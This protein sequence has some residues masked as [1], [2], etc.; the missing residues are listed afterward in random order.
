MVDKLSSNMDKSQRKVKDLKQNVANANK[1]LENTERISNRLSRSVGKLA[2]AFAIKE[3]VANVTKVRGQFQQLE[4]A[5]TTMLQSAEKADAL[6]QQL[7]KTAATTPFGLEDVAQGA[8]QL[9][10]YGFEAEKVNE[11]LIRLGD[12]AAG[13]SVPLNDLVYLYGTTMAQ[14]RL[15]TQDL[16]QFTGRGIPMIS[17]LAKQFGVAESKVKELVEEGKVGFPEVQKVIESLTNEGG[18]F[19]GLMEAQS[20]TITGQISNIEDSFQMM[21]NDIGQ[22]SEGVIN[23]SLRGVSYMLEHY[24]QLG[25]VLLGLAGTYGA[26]KAAIMAVAAARGFSTAAEVLEY[27]WLLMVERAQKTLNATMLS[28]PYVLVATAIAGVVAAMISMRTEA[29]RIKAADEAYEEQKR[30]AIESEEARRKKIE[31]LCTAAGNEAVSTDTR[32]EALNRLEQ[33]YPDIFAKYDTEYE[34]L[35]SLKKIKEEIAELEGSKSISRPQNELAEVEK[36]IKELESK[37]GRTQNLPSGMRRYGHLAGRSQEEE[38]ELQSLYKR[39]GTLTTAVRK[40]AA[41]AYFETLTGV[42][43]ETLSQQ[44][45]QRETLL[46]KMSMDEKKYGTIT[47]GA[48]VLRGTYSREELQYQLNKLRDER[49]RRATPTGSSAEWSKEA[50]KKYVDALSAYNAFLSANNNSMTREEFEKKA[51]ELKEAVDAANKAYDAAKPGKDVDGESQSR[52]LRKANEAAERRKQ[53]KEK[54]GQELVALQHDNDAAETEAMKEGLDKKLRQID[55]DYDA[56]KQEIDKKEAEWQRENKKAG[57]GEGLTEEQQSAIEKAREENDARKERAVAEAYS[58]EAQAMNEFLRAYGTYQ[59]KKLAIA[60]EYAEKIRKAGTEGE[61]LRLSAERDAEVARLDANRMAADIDWSAAFSG[62]GTVLS[63]MARDVLDKVRAY[64]KTDDYK[65]LGPEQKKVYADLAERLRGETG[66]GNVFNFKI[67]GTVA[68]DVTRYQESVRALM[69]AEERH[70]EAVDA[71]TAAKK[72]EAAATDDASKA[73]AT[74]ATA[75]AQSMVEETAG[76]LR[77]AQASKDSAQLRLRRSSEE[78]AQGIEDFKNAISE[79]SNGSLYGF[80]NGITKL[81]TGIGGVSKGLG[82][83]G[84]KVGG[85]IGAILQIID[86]LGDDPAQ[87]IED[88]LDKVGNVVHQVLADLPNIIKT[89]ASG[90]GNIVT[91]AISGIGEMFGA[92]MTGI[93]GGGTDNFDAATDKWGYL[94]DTWQENLEYERELI[95]EAYSKDVSSVAAKTVDS[96]RQTQQA[97]R[98]IYRGWASDGAGLFSHSNGYEANRDAKWGYLWAYD[99]ELARLAGV[100]NDP[101]STRLE[102]ILSGGQ[103]GDISRLFDLPVDKLKELK[104]NNSQFWQSLTETARQYLEQIISIEDEIAAVEAQAKEAVTGISLDN[105]KENWKSMLKDM[106]N[107]ATDLMDDMKKKMAEAVIDAEA[108]ALFGERMKAIYDKWAYSM[109]NNG[110]LDGWEQD[111]I[112]PEM[113]QLTSEMAAWRDRRMR[114]LGYS[115]DSSVTQSGKAGAF[116]TMSQ[117]QGGKLEGL[118]VSGQMHWSSM[119]DKLTDVTRQ[120]TEAGDHLR[121]IATNTGSSAQSLGEIKEDIKKMIRDGVKV[122]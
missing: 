76:A 116:T 89:V 96:L 56:R 44:I 77:D 91:G 97:A 59:Q 66:G 12:I 111:V 47:Y 71:L 85:L 11:T 107:D 29:E 18:K 106:G 68:E 88:L 17:E 120:M 93:F 32:R 62:V 65:K 69:T 70:T 58:D 34:K 79:M 22:Q 110:T 13:L 115:G 78:A 42:G 10:A 36:R 54:L 83:L 63:D 25:R 74:A 61:R 119:D 114:E 49:N 60:E 109:Q 38:A 75:N 1:E 50:R 2:G 80:A 16:N 108:E 40:A 8:K 33:K 3:V 31:E 99:E 6:M 102:D 112:E 19:G 104:Y 81:V 87:F 35:K 30:K 21:L 113:A 72:K 51:K 101:N 24:E 73:L 86:A 67:W 39:R 103:Y 92:D 23:A 90:V 55:N 43:N 105:F 37:T 20:K 100:T 84:G 15:Y 94:L 52:A 14:G 121:Q 53:L 98:D 122:K 117:E 46:A 9:L 7:T 95:E 28:N 57:L 82:E 45:R 26:Y 27:N 5:F 64:M 118:F 4:V 48:A 41:E